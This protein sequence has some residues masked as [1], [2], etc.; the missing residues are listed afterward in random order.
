MSVKYIA[1]LHLFDTY[2][3]DWRTGT[4]ESYAKQLTDIWNE[5]VSPNDTVI[6]VGD[7]GFNCSKTIEMIRNL[8][9]EKVLV[10]GNH[11]ILWY[12]TIQE[13]FV[14]KA[15]YNYMHQDGVLIKHITREKPDNSYF[16]H[17]H[18]HT[19]MHPN[20][21]QC[22]IDYARDTYRLNCAADLINNK[23]STLQELILK[24][25]ILLDD[26]RQRGFLKEVKC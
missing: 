12:K 1:D 22:L 10:V 21:R 8:K 11:D 6:V 4:L 19:Y 7:I 9:G 18:H 23:P 2:S 16:I 5:T 15:M 25:E 3:L 24:K 13:S 26:M 20:M 17:G 14:F